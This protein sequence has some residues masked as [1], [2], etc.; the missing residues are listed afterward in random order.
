MQAT[1]QELLSVFESDGLWTGP[2]RPEAVASADLPEPYRGLLDHERDMTGTLEDFWSAKLVL[3]PL[4]ARRE[5]ELLL[6]RVVLLAGER[7]VE[8]GAIRI[9]LDAFEEPARSR[10]EE[11]RTPF[12]AILRE[13]GLEHR[14]QARSFFRI[15]ADRRT[16]AELSLAETPTAPLLYGRLAHLMGAEG[17]TLAQVVEILPP[18]D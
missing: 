12:G 11:A 13:Q 14:C 1:L 17:R 18:T 3:R 15:A 7:P 9:H 16:C 8:Y 4:E 6:R 10:I 2:E 5:G